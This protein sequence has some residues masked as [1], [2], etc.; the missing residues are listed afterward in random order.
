M[1]PFDGRF[2]G[3]TNSISAKYEVWQRELVCDSDKDFLLKGIAHGFRISSI[4]DSSQVRVSKIPNHSSALKHSSLVES[5]W[6]EQISLDHYV[7]TETT[8]YV[9][10]PIGAILKTPKEVR[11]IHDGSR[12]RWCNG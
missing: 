11:I 10:S 6:K 2:Y 9:V 12:R 3:N 1:S 4:E 7:K 8:P 5:E